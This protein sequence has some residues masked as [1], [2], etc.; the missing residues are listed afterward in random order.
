VPSKEQ[1]EQLLYT[2]VVAYKDNKDVQVITQYS[3]TTI[4]IIL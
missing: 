1:L 2:I 3:T 4:R